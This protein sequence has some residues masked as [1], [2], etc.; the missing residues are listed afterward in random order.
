[1]SIEAK[2]LSQVVS[3]AI[4]ILTSQIGPADTARFINHFSAGLGNY[5]EERKQLY[6]RY[7]VH[8]IVREIKKDKARR[9]K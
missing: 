2:P 7:T 8:D 5:T 4:R 6:A 3:N 1:M 9:R